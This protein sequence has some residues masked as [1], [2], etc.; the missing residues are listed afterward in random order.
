MK[1]SPRDG[2]SRLV[3]GGT[4]YRERSLDEVIDD[5]G[6]GWAQRLFTVVG[7]G[8]CFL[9][10]SIKQLVGVVALAVAADFNF[11]DVQRG[12]LA[13]IVFVGNFSGNLCAGLAD[14]YGR[15]S[16]ALVG[17]GTTFLG[18]VLS[19]FAGAFWSQLVC[20]FTLGFGFGFGGPPFFTL[21][22]EICPSTERLYFSAGAGMSTFT[23]GMAFGLVL[24]YLQDPDLGSGL[25]WRELT[26]YT[27]APGLVILAMAVFFLPESPR[28][29]AATGRR[30]EAVK[31]LEKMREQNGRPDVAVNDWTFVETTRDDLGWSFIWHRS[32]R[33]TTVTLCLSTFVLNYT[34][35]GGIYALPQ[36]LPSLELGVSTAMNLL[37][38]CLIELFGYGLALMV[39]TH[40][41]RVNAMVIYLSSIFVLSAL[42]A[43]MLPQ[44]P[45]SG[46][47]LTREHFAPLACAVL[48][49]YGQRLVIAIG[50]TVVYLYACE[51]YPTAVRAS[52][53][54][55]A[56]AFGRIGSILAPL[57]FEVAVD[58]FWWSTTLLCA[59]NCV[60]VTTLP[61]L[62]KDRPL[63]DIANEVCPINKVP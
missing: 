20:R 41:S 56:I 14:T 40:V 8:L 52:G 49:I 35:Y 58:F 62:T 17:S 36:V 33:C 2:L 32:M 15:R 29:Y 59:V 3:V 54:A 53:A 28:F 7:G 4:T 25:D 30:E 11:S 44:L 27:S 6:F 45:V 60:A 55:F 21:L 9:S 57:S 22:N 26:A 12:W 19:T 39:G 16:L 10:G 18:W 38:A 31:C 42:F 13:S 51:V 23:L 63:G 5:L 34:Y 43:V 47:E 37:L 50:W 1:D 46:T 61:L 24:V 48:S